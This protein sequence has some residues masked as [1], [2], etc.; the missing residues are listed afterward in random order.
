MG[1]KEFDDVS[2]VGLYVT[3]EK[4]RAEMKRLAAK[5]G[6]GFLFNPGGGEFTSPYIPA[7]MLW[8]VKAK[9]ARLLPAKFIQPCLGVD[10]DKVP[11]GDGWIHE[12]KH[13]GYRM[14][15]RKDGDRVRLFTRRG[16]DW[17]ER[18]PRIVAAA[19]KVKAASFTMDGETVCVD[20][21]ALPT[22]PSCTRDASTGK[23]SS[24]PST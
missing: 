12:I 15:V 7:I 20:E 21:T 8:R 13:D 18:Y 5:H 10:S 1:E 3:S 6:L 11:A 17:T 4:A 22:S 24:M 9:P 23:R 16:F 14:Q 19:L 2:N